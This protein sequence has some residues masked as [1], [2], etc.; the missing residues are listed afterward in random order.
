[1]PSPI[2]TPRRDWRLKLIE[3]TRGNQSLLGCIVLAAIGKTPKNPPY[4]TGSATITGAGDV[5]CDFVERDRTYRVAAKIGDDD[6]LARNILGLVI[7]CGL[8]DEERVE[9][10]A[11]VN[12]WIA[13]DHR[14]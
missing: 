12:R 7:H 3:A 5:L 2:V 10:L 6:D 13:R 1:M 4:F 9:F 14:D 8:T 11:R